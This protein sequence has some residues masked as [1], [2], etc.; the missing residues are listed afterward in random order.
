[1]AIRDLPVRSDLKPVGL[2]GTLGRRWRKE[3][4]DFW[5]RLSPLG[6][7]RQSA[8]G[9]TAPTRPEPPDPETEAFSAKLQR[10][11]EIE[12]EEARRDAAGF[13]SADTE[14]D[15]RSSAINGSMDDREDNAEEEPWR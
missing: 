13:G 5:R 6:A 3:D 1:M 15:L 8:T 14:Q 2:S 10:L 12:L 4:P 7:G 11:R 9:E